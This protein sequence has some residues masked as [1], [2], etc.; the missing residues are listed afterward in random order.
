[1]SAGPHEVLDLASR[2]LWR[3]FER[4]MAA[5]QTRPQTL[6]T[7]GY[8]IIRLHQHAGVPLADI[9]R[10]Q[11]QAWLAD[12]GRQRTSSTVDT[13]YRAVR[14][15]YGWAAKLELLDRNPVTAIERPQLATK[16]VEVVPDA[17][18]KRL[19][20][21]C[22]GKT[23]RDRRDLALIRLLAETGPR[24][25]ELCGV[26]LADIDIFSDHILI[27]EG[28]WARERLIPFGHATGLALTAAMRA[29]P[30]TAGTDHAWTGTRAPYE[31]LTRS[32]LQQML[33][34]RCQLA[35][36]PRIHPHQ[37]RHTA[38]SRFFQRGGTERDAMKI[39]GWVKDEMCK[40]YGAAAAGRV[41]LANFREMGLGEDF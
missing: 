2:A 38:V 17:D 29:R 35:G 36:I 14:R 19:V 11:V 23:W 16:V 40:L 27:R 26:R 39:F 12:L 25:S 37:L 21:A 28:K 30:R 4:T 15:F 13:Y 1:M 24:A 5:K 20:R 22:A 34:Y 32:G 33:A 18:L 10:E 6:T 41:A 8:A 31:P 9:T 3:D 7:Y